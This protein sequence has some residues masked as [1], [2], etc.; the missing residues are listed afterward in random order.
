MGKIEFLP[1][2]DGVDH[3]FIYSQDRVNSQID[4]SHLKR[5]IDIVYNIHCQTLFIIAA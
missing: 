1:T 2:V 3:H 4:F 5:I